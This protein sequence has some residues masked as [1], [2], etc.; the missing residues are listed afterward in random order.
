MQRDFRYWQSQRIAEKRATKCHAYM[1]TDKYPTGIPPELYPVHAN[2]SRFILK[3]PL[4]YKDLWIQTFIPVQNHS[5]LKS[6]WDFQLISV[7]L[8]TRK[9]CKLQLIFCYDHLNWPYKWHRRYQRIMY[10]TKHTK[11]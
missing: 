3:Q 9:G 7:T 4:S 11:S 10:L 5:H 6:W 2:V 1:N 8:H